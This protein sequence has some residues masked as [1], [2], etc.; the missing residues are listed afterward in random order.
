[1]TRGLTGTFLAALVAAA[2]VA[3]VGAPACGQEPKA[4][5]AEPKPADAKPE[6]NK[7]QERPKTPKTPW[8]ENTLFA[9]VGHQPGPAVHILSVGG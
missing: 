7:E 2:C 9:Y 6:E 4:A 1:M 3:A 5:P 8:D